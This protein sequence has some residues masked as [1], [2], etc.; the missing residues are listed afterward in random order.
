MPGHSEQNETELSA[1]K[2]EILHF[3]QNDIW[4]LIAYCVAFCRRLLL[5]GAFFLFDIPLLAGVNYAW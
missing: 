3:V 2:R 1:I 4:G 5:F